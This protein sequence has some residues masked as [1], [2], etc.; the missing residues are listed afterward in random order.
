[1]PHNKTA[2]LLLASFF[3]AD[4]GEHKTIT[5][6]K[7]IGFLLIKPLERLNFI[8]KNILPLVRRTVDLHFTL[9]LHSLKVAGSIPYGVIGNFH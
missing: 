2:K 1:M 8:H 3:I 9:Y 6:K 7:N 4:K 5:P